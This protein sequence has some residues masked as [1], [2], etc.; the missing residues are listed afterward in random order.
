MSVVHEFWMIEI[1]LWIIVAVVLGFT[2]LGIYLIHRKDKRTY[3]LGVALF[4]FLF[5]I[6]RIS[7]S[8]L[9]YGYLYDGTEQYLL[10]YP[11]LLWL[12][13]GYNLFS[14]TGIFILYF[15]LERYIIKTK[16]IFS[17]TTIILLLSLIHI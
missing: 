6:A 11:T 14:Y 13:I 8:F 5:L 9:V 15:V 3:T 17:A 12:Q 16:Y 1:V 2:S 7:V 4:L 10:P